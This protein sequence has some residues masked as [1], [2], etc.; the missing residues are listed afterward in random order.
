MAP[1]ATQALAALR[2]RRV[3]VTGAS[4]F[5]GSSLC[6]RLLALGAEVHAVSRQGASGTGSVRA[7]TVDPADFAGL[8][9]VFSE[10]RPE[11]VFHLAGH[12]YGAREL[13]HVR[14]ALLGN[15]FSTVTVLELATASRCE[16]V[17]V[18]GSQDEP[19][20]DEQHD[21]HFVPSSPY[22]A[23]KF[24]SSAYARMFAALYRLPVSIGRIL[25][26][27]GPGQRDLQKLVPYV[28]RSLARGETPRLGTGSR[29]LD[30]I[31]ID[32]VVTGLLLIC[33]TA[34][35]DGRTI[36][37]GT[38]TMHTAREAV[39]KIVTLMGS[40]I[41]QDFGSVAARQLERARAANV[42]A[43]RAALGWCPGTSFESG[44]QRTIDWYT[45]RVHCEPQRAPDKD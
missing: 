28:I 30:W 39:E 12:V 8:Q 21:A 41:V 20:V 5:I 1:A 29:P 34:G 2:A 7:W 10:A 45:E 22:A 23:S 44:L 19:E 4:G 37:L 3:L 16:R 24:A 18:T 15:L 40:G 13:A 25:M 32:D 11:I 38:G 6:E 27:Y 43:T 31:Y 26:A 42:D 9:A 35:L 17:V 14:P 36:D 33:V